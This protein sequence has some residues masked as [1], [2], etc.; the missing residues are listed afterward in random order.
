MPDKITMDDIARVT[1][2]YFFSDEERIADTLWM[3]NSAGQADAFED[4]LKEAQRRGY[5]RERLVN[6]AHRKKWK[7]I[8]LLQNRQP[9]KMG[10]GS[11]IKSPFSYPSGMRD[12]STDPD[13]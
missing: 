4:Y 3:L 7:L 13:K 5:D 9:V 8:D 12:A 10:G 2:D 6:L 1:L 11:E